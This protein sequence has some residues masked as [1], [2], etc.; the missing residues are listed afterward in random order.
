VLPSVVVT[1]GQ[2]HWCGC[3]RCFQPDHCQQQLGSYRL[4]PRPELQE[5]S[6]PVRYDVT[7]S[8]NRV[9]RISI[10]ALAWLTIMSNGQAATAYTQ[11]EKVVPFKW[12]ID[13]VDG[14]HRLTFVV[15]TGY[16]GGKPEPSIDHITKIWHPRSLVMT[17]FL[18]FPEV[19]F[20]ENEAC[21][22]VGLGISRQLRFKRSI[23]HRVIYDGSTSPPRR[24]WRPPH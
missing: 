20:A 6:V 24:R 18:R 8:L 13:S 1:V 11:P 4:A 12:T 22:G 9:V 2:Q 16:C 10:A 15:V 17:V 3:G 7:V 14:P 23:S 19:H 21:A 5:V